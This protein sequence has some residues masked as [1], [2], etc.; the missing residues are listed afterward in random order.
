LPLCIINYFFL[1]T[2]SSITWVYID[3]SWYTNSLWIRKL[4][5]IES[6]CILYMPQLW[7]THNSIYAKIQLSRTFQ[8]HRRHT[9]ILYVIFFLS[10]VIVPKWWSSVV[11][12]MKNN[13]LHRRENA[14]Y[15][16]KK[17]KYICPTYGLCAHQ[18]FS[19]Y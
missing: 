18:V 19:A 3:I 6:S 17:F 10:F 8:A 2:A 9:L 7:N 1:R 16:V 13:D 4:S 11:L 12:H 5:T 14:C 15:L